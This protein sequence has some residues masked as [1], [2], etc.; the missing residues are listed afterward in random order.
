LEELIST[1][2]KLC[3]GQDDADRKAMK[4]GVEALARAAE[5]REHNATGHG[6]QCAHYAG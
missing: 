1:L 2:R 4:E 5:L 3:G 6:E